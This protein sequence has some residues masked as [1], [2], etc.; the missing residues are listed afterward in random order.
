MSPV[1]PGLL[2][3]IAAGRRMAA[4]AA[5]IAKHNDFE[6][7]SDGTQ[8]TVAN[9][10]DGGA[11]AFS[12][13]DVADALG[14]YSRV[15]TLH[16][17]SGTRCFDAHRGTAGISGGT[18]LVRWTFTGTALDTYIRYYVMFPTDGTVIDRYMLVAQNIYLRATAR[19]SGNYTLDWVSTS[20]G[21]VGSTP[22]VILGMSKNAW[23]RMEH[24]IRFNSSGGL[25]NEIETR[26]FLNPDSTTPT[27]TWTTGHASGFGQ[28]TLTGIA[29]GTTIGGTSAGTSNYSTYFDDFAYSFTGWIGL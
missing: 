9:S 15:S 27:S 4:P 11:D 1:N 17:K 21:S 12:S 5:V 23:I 13:V 22:V 6:F 7:A 25:T 20:F 26:T 29:L 24:R 2:G 3:A 14:A 10:D 18:S 8:I 19:D 16:A 28:A